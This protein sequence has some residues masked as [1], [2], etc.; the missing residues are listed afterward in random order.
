MGSSDSSGG[1]RTAFLRESSS[2]LPGTLWRESLDGVSLEYPQDS[3]TLGTLTVSFGRDEIMVSVGG[4]GFHT[5][6]GVDEVQA[7]ATGDQITPVA[8][9]ALRFV[10]DVIEDRVSIRSG[11]LVS[12]AHSSKRGTST[13]GRLW[14]WLTP[15]VQEVVWSGRHDH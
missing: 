8:T 5:H 10:R 11:I 3:P 12:S 7:P 14:K 4:R 15:W 1:L 13:V 9:A 2:V 6:F